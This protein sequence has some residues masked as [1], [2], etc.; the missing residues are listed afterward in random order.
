M[1][2]KRILQENEILSFIAAWEIVFDRTWDKDSYNWLFNKN[3]RIYCATDN[4]KVVGGY[5]LLELTACANNQILKGVLCNNVFINGFKYQKQGLFKDITNFALNHA[6]S[7]CDFA[8]GFPNKKAIKAHLRCGW[9]QEK[10]VP[11]LEFK[12][13]TLSNTPINNIEIKWFNIDNK[14]SLEALDN[15]F[16]IKNTPNISFFIHKSKQFLKWRFI[17]NPRCVYQMGI[18]SN[19]GTLTGFFVSKF[20][21]ERARIHLVDYYFEDKACINTSVNSIF[22]YYHSKGMSAEIIDLWSATADSNK[23]ITAGFQKADAFTDVIFQDLN[24]TGVSLG[25]LPHLV[26]ADN[27]VY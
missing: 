16:C 9:T 25:K 24:N 23:F 7:D 13:N 12:Y 11:F 5:C 14:E 19:D 6:K 2:I 26:L 22:K 20:F 1:K 18:I 4:G 10:S 17:D 15:C 3:N 8:L 21:Q 27:D